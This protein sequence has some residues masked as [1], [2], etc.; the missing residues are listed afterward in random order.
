MS[1]DAPEPDSE[2]QT[3]VRFYPKLTDV[4]VALRLLGSIGW[5]VETIEHP[6]NSRLLRLPI[7]ILRGVSQRH[8][9]RVTYVR[10]RF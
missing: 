3:L 9:Y 6:D 2:A 1:D 5:R 7:C 8:R 10:R 4:G